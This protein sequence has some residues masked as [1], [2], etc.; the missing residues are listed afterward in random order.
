MENIK[1]SVLTEAQYQ[2][3]VSKEPRGYYDNR[4]REQ[5]YSLIE[6]LADHKNYCTKEETRLH[7]RLQNAE[8]G[9]LLPGNRKTNG[10][11]K[12]KVSLCLD[13]EHEGD[14][15]TGGTL[16]I[17]EKGCVQGNISAEEI[18][19]KGKMTGDVSAGQKL[20]LHSTGSLMGDVVAP[21]VQIAPG[22]MFK[23]K[24]KLGNP[25]LKAARKKEE[26][27]PIKNRIIQLFRAG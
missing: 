7:K 5:L 19:C 17:N 10:P 14:I 9:I 20:T 16:I 22:A 23:G 12:F 15:T 1:L 24:C 27:V 3:L 26:R 2:F 8:F 6:K 25:E 21:A 13:G 11:L 4:T 18:I